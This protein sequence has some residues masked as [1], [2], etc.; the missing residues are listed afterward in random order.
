ML[1]TEI[2][3]SPA[4]FATLVISAAFFDIHAELY[5]Q[6]LQYLYFTLLLLWR[7]VH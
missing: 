7:S 3:L 2:L 5:K 6:L 1:S 4:C